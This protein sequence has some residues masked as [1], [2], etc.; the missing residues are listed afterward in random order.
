MFMIHLPKSPSAMKMGWTCL[1]SIKMPWKQNV[2]FDSVCMVGK[3]WMLEKC[4]G[5]GK[6]GWQLITGITEPSCVQNALS[7]PRL[8][9][10]YNI[11]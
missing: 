1:G 5:K 11:N 8:S 7:W 2:I 6:T 3:S 9:V 4:F 10:C